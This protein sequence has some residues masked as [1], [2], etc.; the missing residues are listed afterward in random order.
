MTGYG[1]SAQREADRHRQTDFRF[2]HTLRKRRHWLGAHDERH[3]LVIE[4]GVARTFH[5]APRCDVTVAVDAEGKRH[6]ALL[7]ARPRLA[8]IALGL[9]QLAK[10][11][12]LPGRLDP[13]RAALDRGGRP[14]LLELDRRLFLLR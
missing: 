12:A 8:R 14:L 7:A 9:L 11:S 6:D 1:A 2:D 5:D 4:R 10:Q 13:R 3:R